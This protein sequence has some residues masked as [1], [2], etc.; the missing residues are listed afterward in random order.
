LVRVHL[1]GVSP[2]PTPEFEGRRQ[3]THRAKSLRLGVWEL[4]SGNGCEVWWDRAHGI[5][6]AWDVP[7]EAGWSEGDH[8]DYMERVMPAV[9]AR[10]AE[11][12]GE[13]VVAVGGREGELI[14]K[15]PRAEPPV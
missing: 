8:R 2:G 9:V 15:A 12:A 10:V 1:F 14:V 3:V 4:P 13:L 6:F 5:I 7:P 11:I